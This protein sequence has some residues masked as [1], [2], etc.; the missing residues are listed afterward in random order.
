MSS[1]AAPL[2]RFGVVADPQYADLAPNVALNRYFRI[3]LA[4]LAE[5]ITEFNGADLAFVVTLGDVIDGIWESFDA[6]LPIY[7]QLKHPRYFLLG[8]HDF[9]VG[10][11]RLASVF[12]RVGMRDPYYDFAVAGHRFVMLDGNE[13]S[14]FAPPENDP[15]RAL[16]EKRLEA[17]RSEGAINAQPWNASL[18]DVQFLWLRAVLKKAQTAGERV[19]VMG[20]YPIYPPN[21]HNMWDDQRIV[22]LLAEHDNAVAYLCG[23]NHAGNFGTHG[24]THF[25]N[26]KGM[27]DTPDQNTFAIVSVYPDRLEIE[28]FGREE[29]RIL[30]IPSLAL[31]D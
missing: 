26:F 29:N 18:G 13:V 22:D 17:L 4:R 30:S 19:I 5:A 16:A 10:P 6:I 28:G 23:H 11:D 31:P 20:H 27:V 9:A 14:L 8:N 2:F 7:E 1:A 21:E 12:A 24:N 15:R 25:I 3:S